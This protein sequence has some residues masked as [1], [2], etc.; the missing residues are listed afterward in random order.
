MILNNFTPKRDGDDAIII[1]GDASNAPQAKK[2]M[3]ALLL[4]K[5][6]PEHA[7]KL[8]DVKIISKVPGC[9][10]PEAVKSF[11]GGSETQ[12]MA[13]QKFIDS[14]LPTRLVEREVTSLKSRLQT[15]VNSFTTAK[16]DREDRIKQMKDILRDSR[17]HGQSTADAERE[18]EDATIKS[19]D[20]IDSKGIKSGGH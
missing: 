12:E 20:I 9:Q 4:L 13:N 18:L 19:G 5:D 6:N 14:H 15:Q 7:S 16:G 11:L 10:A 2:L 17:E 8:K 3:A 1:E